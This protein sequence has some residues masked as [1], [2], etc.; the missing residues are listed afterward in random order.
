M[1][2]FCKTEFIKDESKYIRVGVDY[3]KVLIKK[4]RY[5]IQRTELKK[6]NKEEITLD[7]GKQILYSIQKFDDFIMIPDNKNQTVSEGNFYNL[8]APFTHEPKKGSYKWTEILLNHIFGEQYEIGIKYIQTLYLHPDQI[9]PVLVLISKERQTGKSTF[10]DWLMTIFGAN[11][12]VITPNDLSREFNGSYS[13]S[14]IIAL[15]ETLIKKDSIVEKVK[16]LSTQKTINANLKNVN[17]FQIPFFGKLIIASNNEHKFMKI[18]TDEI[19]FF[20]RKIGTPKIVNHNILKDMV[21]EIPAF[22]Y[23]LESLPAIDFSK[24]RMIFTPDEISNE[25]LKDVQNES[26]TWL[27]KELVSV[28]ED[29]F[30]NQYNGNILRATPKEIKEMYFNFNNQVTSSYIKDVLLNEFKFIKLDKN[31]SYKSLTTELFKTGQPFLITRNK[32]FNTDFDEKQ[33]IIENDESNVYQQ[34]SIEPPPF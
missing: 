3:F 4:D 26:H 11:M 34:L 9:L 23:Y 29:V 7:H 17:D 22:L 14:N 25:S 18:D 15:E 33:E 19:R 12:V 32:I 6:W 10:I 27:Y 1:K 20:I 28:F 24:S 16:A 21:N 31:I 2:K 5:G 8:Y 13:R 30:N